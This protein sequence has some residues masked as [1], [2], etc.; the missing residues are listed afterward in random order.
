MKEI[1]EDVR[2]DG[3]SN[4]QLIEKAK[5][6]DSVVNEGGEGYNPYRNEIKNRA[7][8][9][10]ASEPKT[11]SDRKAEIA[12]E[13]EIKDCSIARES[14][15][16]NQAEID[17]LETELETIDAEETAEFAAEWTLDVTQT[18]RADWNAFIRTLIGKDGRIASSQAGKM[19]TR[20]RAQGWSMSD[21]KKAV[22]LHNLTPAP[23]K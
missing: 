13:L 16:Y 20:E 11:R 15:T 21:L 1:Y 2:G 6:F 23:K 14:G 10:A 22:T 9:A 12:H 18:R 3:L 4:A 5:E 8:E 17:A 19:A 7:M